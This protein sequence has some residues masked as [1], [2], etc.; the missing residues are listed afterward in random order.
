MRSTQLQTMKTQRELVHINGII[1]NYL[2][3]YEIKGL[4]GQDNAFSL[5]KQAL[6]SI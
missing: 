2:S 3:Q 4:Q 5:R 6:R 1:N